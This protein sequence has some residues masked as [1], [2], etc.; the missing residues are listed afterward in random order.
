MGYKVSSLRTLPVI[1]GIELYVFILGR[2]IWASGWRKELERNFNKL[3]RELGSSAAIVSGHDRTNLIIE[4]M[5]S[6]RENNNL[7]IA[8]AL[9]RQ[10]E[11]CL[12]LL[13]AHPSELSDDDLVLLINEEHIQSRFGNMEV[14]L[15]ELC[16]FAKN[17]NESF[18][19]K[20][21][22]EKLLTDDILGVIDLKPNFFG[23]GVNLN[24]AIEKFRNWKNKDA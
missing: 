11:T 17:R 7:S 6:A 8:Q 21:Q 14:F 10:D 19:E 1:P 23:F 16:E 13:G 15:D 24:K 9:E 12:L 22:E 18:L 3:A 5:E 20:F 2:N 4:L